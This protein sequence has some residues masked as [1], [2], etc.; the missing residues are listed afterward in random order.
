[1]LWSQDPQTL[2]QGL[3]LA[4][5]ALALND[6]LPVAHRVLC[7]TYVWKKQHDLAIAEGLKAV[8]LDPNDADSYSMLSQTL[9]FAGKP[10]EAIGFAEKAMRL[11]PHYPAAYINSLGWAYAL[12]GRDEE[13]IAAVKP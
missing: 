4:Q 6:S 2:E 5:K 12:L 8:A 3:V 9:N 1:L 13:A 10:E 7:W 11:N